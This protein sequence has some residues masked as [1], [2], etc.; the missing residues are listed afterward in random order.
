MMM[1]LLFLLPFLVVNA[2]CIEVGVLDESGTR[3]NASLFHFIG[4]YHDLFSSEIS[5]FNN[6]NGKF[7][8]K[9]L[10]ARPDP[11]NSSS[12]VNS[13]K[14]FL[15]EENGITLEKKRINDFISE[16]ERDDWD[17]IMIC[18]NS[19][20][21]HHG[22]L[23]IYRL[24]TFIPNEFID[25]ISFPRA[26]LSK[27]YQEHDGWEI[28]LRKDMTRNI[29]YLLPSFSKKIAC[30]C[31]ILLLKIILSDVFIAVQSKNE[32]N[33]KEGSVIK[34]ERQNDTQAIKSLKSFVCIHIS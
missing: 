23:T 28:T 34:L 33:Y 16:F 30:T 4:H 31:A 1:N 21:V 12:N 20:S 9:I 8:L 3:I 15:I 18:P 24:M 32:W 26:I 7:A 5:F 13:E 17:A 14:S 27:S 10:L 25:T 2:K 19:P 29:I 6:P 22:T 11:K